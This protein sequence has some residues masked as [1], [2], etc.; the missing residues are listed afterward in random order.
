MK[1]I[2]QLLVICL[3]CFIIHTQAG[4]TKGND[5]TPTPEPID[6]IPTPPT[7]TTPPPPKVK[8]RVLTQYSYDAGAWGNISSTNG[9]IRYD[10]LGRV[11]SFDANAKNGY[12]VI[13]NK[14]TI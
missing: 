3:A 10:S 14:D 9:S 2:F 5:V 8:K 1:T 6:S 7:N 4:C 11:N 13:Y 12:K